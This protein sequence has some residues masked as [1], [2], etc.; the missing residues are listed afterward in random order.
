[1]TSE[2]INIEGTGFGRIGIDANGIRVN[3]VN[4]HLEVYD[5]AKRTR[6]LNALMTWARQ[7]SAPRL[8]GGDF[9]AWWG[10]SWIR[11]ME[12][13]YSDTWQDVTGSDQNGYTIGNVRFDY[14]FRAPGTTWLL[15]PAACVVVPTSASDHRPVVAEYVLR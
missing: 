6:Q 8:V 10:E 4:A 9:N 11:T 12:T 15:P 2:K 7:V 5:T 14:L 3:V 13:E 1:V